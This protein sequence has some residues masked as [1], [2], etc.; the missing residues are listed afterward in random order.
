MADDETAPGDR[1]PLD[2]TGGRMTYAGVGVDYETLDPVKLLA[3][4]AAASTAPNLSRWGFSEVAASRGESAYVWEELDC[5][6]AFVVEGL[7]TKSLVADAMREVTGRTYYDQ[8]AQD[9]V[10][11]IVNDVVVVGAAPQVVNAFWATGSSDWME[12]EER[13]ADL[14][15]GWAAAVDA[16]GAVWGGGET[17]TLVGLVESTAIDLAGACIGIIAPKSRLILGDRLAPG[18][19]IVA[20]GSSGIHANGLTLAR[21]IATRLPAGYATELTDGT[22]YGEALLA[23]TH[24]YPGLVADVFESGADVHYLANITGHGWRKLMRASA[25]LRYVVSE[26]PEPSPLFQLMVEHGQLDLTEAYGNLNMGMGFAI[27]VPERD[28]SKALA[29]AEG[30]GFGAWVAGHVEEGPRQVAIEPLG[31]EF[32]GGSLEVR[33]NV[34]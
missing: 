5:Y 17:E 7:G 13:A 23:P 28:V 11:M 25:E 34:Q 4:R 8:L 20:V 14:V 10:A 15:R 18:D 9:T 29:A 30:Q 31:I 1:R 26:V 32:A 33:G 2:A 6:R 22:M 3:Q 16:S 12:D 24:L 21:Q 19:A 27:M